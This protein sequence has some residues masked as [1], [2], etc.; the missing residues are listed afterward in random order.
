MKSRAKKGGEIAMNG[1]FYKGGSFLPSTHLPKQRPIKTAQPKPKKPLTDWQIE[2]INKAIEGTKK[3]IEK[4]RLEGNQNGVD[5]N[6]A[7]MESLIKKLAQSK[8]HI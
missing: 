7:Y 2:S 6:E 4:C 1:E 5:A 3:Q 8:Q